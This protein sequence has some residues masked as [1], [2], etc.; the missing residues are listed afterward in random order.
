MKKS[1]KP[2]KEKIREKSEKPEKETRGAVP[3]NH[4]SSLELKNN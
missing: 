3:A 1:E 2:E 4:S